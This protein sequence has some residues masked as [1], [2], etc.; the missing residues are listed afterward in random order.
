MLIPP[1]CI[2]FILV[3]TKFA[4]NLGSAVRAMKNM[5]FEN[6][7]LVQPECEIGVEART[8]AMK[9]AN[10]LDRA[11]FYPSLQAASQEV[12]LLVGTTG[13]FETE[14][15]LLTT[16]RTFAQEIV[17][18]YSGTK[19]GIAFGPEDN[20]LRRE[21]LRLCQWWVQIPTGPDSPVINLAQA[22]AIVAYELHLAQQAE[23]A[24]DYLHRA[25]EEEVRLLLQRAEEFFQ[26]LDLPKRISVNRLMKRIRKLTPRAQLEKE[27]VNLLH[28]LLT[29]I[30]KAVKKA[31]QEPPEGAE[32]NSLGRKPQ[33][34]NGK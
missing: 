11:V 12:G 26:S 33:E 20:G 14:K 17:P 6:L 2:H 25:T 28:S 23:S 32:E 30:A 13:R 4:S 31:K 27:D 3:R 9:G 19:I 15:H 10:I 16:S 1:D 5:G 7:T 18:R 34:P 21:E 8:L 22:V 24:R 29:E